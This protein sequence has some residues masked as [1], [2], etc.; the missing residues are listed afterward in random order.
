[1]VSIK[2]HLEARQ[3]VGVNSYVPWSG[4]NGVRRW[5]A[6]LVVTVRI[7]LLYVRGCTNHAAAL[8]MIRDVLFEAELPERVY[9]I[10]VG[11]SAAASALAFP[12][13]PTIRVN[14]RDVEPGITPQGQYGVCCRTY[15]VNGKRQ[16]LPE[17][18]WIRQALL[19]ASSRAPYKKSV[20]F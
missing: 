7:E 9:E 12:G 6:V 2:R 10:E 17:R 18:E 11:N 16:G 20:N 19:P 14:G 8:E 4:V 13:S 15:V 5:V 1:M 3:V